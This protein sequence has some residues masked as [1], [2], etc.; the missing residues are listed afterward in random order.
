[1]GVNILRI[2]LTKADFASFDFDTLL[3][4]QGVRIFY[5]DGRV[6]E[7]TVSEYWPTS[8]TLADLMVLDDP[9]KPDSVND[10][11]VPCPEIER[12]EIVRAVDHPNNNG[13][14]P[15]FGFVAPTLD[16]LYGK[17][18]KSNTTT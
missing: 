6:R 17:V 2:M 18:D 10:V 3:R 16:E 7:A 15:E 12:I 4:A 5:K 9:T 8:P 13:S 14:H 11:Y 1:M